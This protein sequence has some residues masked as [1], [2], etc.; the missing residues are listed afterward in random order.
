ML[1]SGAWPLNMDYLNCDDFQGGN[2]PERNIDLR[3]FFTQVCRCTLPSS[4]FL[5][6]ISNYCLQTAFKGQRTDILWHFRPGHA[7]A[8]ALQWLQLHEIRNGHQ[9]APDSR[10]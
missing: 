3:Q 10:R 8:Q 1:Q 7:T 6:I 4:T 2:T 9:R 5:T